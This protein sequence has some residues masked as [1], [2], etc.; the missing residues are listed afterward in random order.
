MSAQPAII[1]HTSA[2][3]QQAPTHLLTLE[4]VM[5]RTG[6]RRTFLYELFATGTIR[7]ARVGRSVRY[8]ES[9][10]EAWIQERITAGRGG[11]K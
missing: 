4:Q 10:V 8:V 5:S 7:R 3:H 6:M 9:D 2:I 11:A 1:S